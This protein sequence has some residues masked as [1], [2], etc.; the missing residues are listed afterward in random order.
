MRLY[1]IKL[2][3]RGIMN[4]KFGMLGVEAIMT[5]FHLCDEGYNI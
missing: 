2:A 3:N 4:I 1:D 5:V